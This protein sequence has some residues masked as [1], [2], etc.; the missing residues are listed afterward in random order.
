[1]TDILRKPRLDIRKEC[2]SPKPFIEVKAFYDREIEALFR[3][4][5]DK[6]LGDSIKY[7]I[8][9]YLAVT[10]FAAMDFFFRNAARNL[11]DDNNLDVIKISTKVG[12]TYSR[13]CYNKGQHSCFNV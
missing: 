2:K 11:I 5:L 4:L 8:R 7:P 9:K 10:I 6:S 13:E 1:M 3:S 12:K